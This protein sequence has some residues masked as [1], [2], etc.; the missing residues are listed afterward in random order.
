MA[1]FENLTVK[2][3]SSLK[4]EFSQTAEAIG[5]PVNTALVLLMT[6]FIEKRGLPFD[7]KSSRSHIDWDDARIIKTSR[8]DGK[9]MMPAAWRDEDDQDLE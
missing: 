8:K 5:I 9:L 6:R 3:P 7:V 4:K 2:L 1:E